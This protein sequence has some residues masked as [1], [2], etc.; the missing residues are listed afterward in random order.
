[1]VINY[2]KSVARVIALCSMISLIHGAQAQNFSVIVDTAIKH[3]VIDGFGAHQSDEDINNPWLS[4][5]YFDD[6]ECSI[7]RVD[8]TPRLRSPFA[9][10]NY[11][12]PWFM[13]STIKHLFNLEDPSNPNGPE[14]NR[15]RTYT[16]PQ[17]YSRTFGGRNAPIAVM[18]PNIE[19]NI[20]YFV[21]APNLIIQQGL[22]KSKKLGGFKLIGSIWSPLPWVKVASGNVYRE[23]WWPGPVANT[24]WP[25]I[26]GGNFAGGRLDVSNTPL[27]VF[28]DLSMGGL[29][30][31]SALTQFARSTAA[32][33]LGYQRF[34]KVEFYAISIQNELNF[35]QFYNSTTYPLSSQYIAALKA[36]RAEFDKYPELIHIKL[37]GPEDLLGGDAYGMWEYG[38][39]N[40]PIH[41]NLQYL[42]SISRD[43]VA[44]RALDFHCV[45]GYA[46]DGV[47]SSGAQPNLWNWWANGWN[48]GPA[49]GIPSNIRGFTH[50]QKKSWMTETSGEHPDWLYPKQGFPGDGA[51]GL[52]IR[53]H[54]ALTT[55]LESAWIYWT[56][57]DSD[58]SGK[59]SAYGLTNVSDQANSPKYNAAKHYFKLIRPG[60]IRIG[61]SVNGTSSIL[62]SAYLTADRQT[63]ALE[64]INSSSSPQQ[65]TLQIPDGI[66]QFARFTSQENAYWQSSNAMAAQQRLT[67]DLPAYSVTSLVGKRITNIQLENLHTNDCKI[68][69][70][71]ISNSSNIDLNITEGDYLTIKLIDAEGRLQ[72]LVMSKQYFPAGKHR[73]AFPSHIVQAGLYFLEISGQ[74]NY[75]VRKLI[76]L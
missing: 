17:D 19:E 34:H 13:G 18:G 50:Y 41:K 46:S 40:G 12:S 64:L 24:A 42:Q 62:V 69:P 68:I 20:P 27:Q 56:F 2:F 28:N 1:M 76:K 7:Y 14:G 36:V 25:F 29:G 48:T 53:I 51:L 9:D 47:T 63:L 59:V 35:E 55:G 58:N 31:T 73:I 33:L 57:S 3:Q 44:F 8:L 26:W 45:H 66:N 10:L 39:S 15:V 61:T 67:I 22:A 6:I 11:F 60:S 5:L 16:G 38:S 71:P 30:P 37:M 49:A 54:Q 4:N 52:A 72:S 70:N 65:G 21:Y 23:N 43:T 32:Y 75:W 74:Q